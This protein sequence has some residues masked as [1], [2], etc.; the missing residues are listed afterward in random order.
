M[1]TEYQTFC[2]E[3]LEQWR[4]WLRSNHD[5]GKVI[6]LVHYKRHT[7]R[8]C[9]DENDA[10][11]EALCFGWIDS[12]IKRIDDDAYMK[13]YTPRVNT[14]KWSAYN[15]ARVKRLIKEGRMQEPGRVK[16]PDEV[17][18]DGYVSYS[19][20]RGEFQVP[21]ELIEFLASYPEALRNFADFPVSAKKVY[22]GWIMSAKREETRTK[23]MLEAVGLLEKNIKNPM[24]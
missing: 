6:W 17:L 11:E 5:T 8:A 9:V 20:K 15:I 1:D 2:A 14:A 3:T 24:K 4:E 22:C 7:G 23:R 10:A 13:K 12:I 16:I 18:E 21:P 19:E